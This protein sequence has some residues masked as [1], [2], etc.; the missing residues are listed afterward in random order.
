LDQQ[1]ILT[2]REDDLLALFADDSYTSQFPHD[3]VSWSLYQEYKANGVLPITG[4][5]FDQPA[6]FWDDV[7][8]FRLSEE[9]ETDI[10]R[11]R[12]YIQERINRLRNGD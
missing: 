2:K 3:A 4:G 10:P 11:D 8:Y 5:Y 7:G 9:L 6:W 1:A 12:R